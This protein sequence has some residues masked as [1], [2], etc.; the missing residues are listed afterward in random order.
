[1]EGCS[2]DCPRPVQ[3]V[4]LEFNSYKDPEAARNL[5]RTCVTLRPRVWYQRAKQTR[6]ISWFDAQLRY[7]ASMP[8]TQWIKTD[9]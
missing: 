8:R 5:L 7:A 6:A 4:R 9:F 2:Q 1:M 3:H